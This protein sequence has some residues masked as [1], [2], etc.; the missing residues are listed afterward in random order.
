MGGVLRFVG[1]EPGQLI[2]GVPAAE[3]PVTLAEPVEK[4]FLGQRRAAVTLALA[5]YSAQ[6]SHHGRIRDRW[7]CQQ[8]SPS[9]S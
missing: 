9:R 1:L 6:A 2:P 4:L 5:P 8:V 3:Q 7:A